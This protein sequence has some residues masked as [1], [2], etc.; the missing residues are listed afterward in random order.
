[1]GWIS[2][3]WTSNLEHNLIRRTVCLWNK[4]RHYKINQSI[5]QIHLISDLCSKRGVTVNRLMLMQHW[6][7]RRQSQNAQWL[8]QCRDWFK[9]REIMNIRYAICGW[10][11]YSLSVETHTLC[12]VN[13]AIR[14]SVGFV[15][16]LFTVA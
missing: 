14:A 10:A 5:H 1:M 13:S 3:I 4:R 2:V 8:V 6:I 12:D 11:S 15:K 16:V 9:S 7:Q